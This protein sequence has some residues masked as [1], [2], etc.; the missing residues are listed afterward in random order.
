MS[1]N[2]KTA[3]NLLGLIEEQRLKIEWE[4][5]LHLIGWVSDAGGDSRAARHR[6]GWAHPE[7]LIADCFAHQVSILFTSIPFLIQILFNRCNLSYQ[8]I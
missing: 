6:F 7:L 1:A 8:T 5:E 2:R 3:N 4:L